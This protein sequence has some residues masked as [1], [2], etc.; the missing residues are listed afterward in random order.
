M[1][2]SAK[3]RTEYQIFLHSLFVKYSIESPD[4]SW[5]NS[6]WKVIVNSRLSDFDRENFY[7]ELSEFNI[8]NPSDENWTHLSHE[9]LKAAERY[10]VEDIK[11]AADRKKIADAKKMKKTADRKKIADVKKVKDM[12]K[13]SERYSSAHAKK[14]KDMNKASESKKN[15]DAKK[16]KDMK[17][18]AERKRIADAKKIDSDTKLMKI[19]YSCKEEIKVD[20]NVCKHCGSLQDTE[21][22]REANRQ[23]NRSLN[24]A[25]IYLPIGAWLIFCIFIG[26]LFGVFDIFDIFDHL[27]H[28]VWHDFYYE[29][30]YEYIAS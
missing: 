8:K 3:N 12:N 13:V 2:E 22:N 14:V 6:L 17:K 29:Y 5:S 15:A 9:E 10:S 30:I 20:A 21:D 18:A 26:H 28:K 24:I 4:E 23:F 25:T 19:C 11:K 1:K 7:K 27:Y 16:D